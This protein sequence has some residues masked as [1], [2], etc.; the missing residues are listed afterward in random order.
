MTHEHTPLAD[1]HNRLINYLRISI[2]DRCNFRCQYCMPAE[3]IPLLNHADILTYEEILRCARIAISLGVR[4]IRV[5]GGEPL[6]RRGVVPL[7]SELSRL[8]GL[9]DLSVTTNGA[10]L[11][12]HATQLRAA[13]LHRVNISLDTLRPDRFTAITRRARPGGRARG[14]PGGRGGRPASHQDQCGHHAERQAGTKSP[15]LRR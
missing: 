1:H 12:R 14:H 3:G 2:T 9:A 15:I 5:T 13:G 6:V 4:K 11:G 7:L 10:L 8:P